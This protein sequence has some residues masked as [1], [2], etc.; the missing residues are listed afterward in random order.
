MSDGDRTIMVAAADPAFIAVREYLL[1]ENGQDF[2]AIRSIVQMSRTLVETF[3][4]SEDGTTW[5]KGEN[6]K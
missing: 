6:N 1:E 2:D 3:G 5:K 4:W